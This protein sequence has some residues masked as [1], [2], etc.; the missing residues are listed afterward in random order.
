MEMTASSLYGSYPTIQ[1]NASGQPDHPAGTPEPT[2]RTQPAP[3][4]VRN[5]VA[6]LMA[7][8][9]LAILLISRLD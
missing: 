5:P 7:V 4:G 2:V 9:G 3:T 8:V 1:P 6:A